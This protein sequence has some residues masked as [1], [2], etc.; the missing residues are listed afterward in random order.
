MFLSV[1]KKRIKKDFQPEPDPFYRV[2]GRRREDCVD[3]V[4]NFTFEE[5]STEA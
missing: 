1:L 3:V 5:T 4:T 2:I